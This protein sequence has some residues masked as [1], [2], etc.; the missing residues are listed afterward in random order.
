MFYHRTFGTGG[1]GACAVCAFMAN[2]PAML[3]AR[4]SPSNLIGGGYASRWV[5]GL[6][7]SVQAGE[8]RGAARSAAADQGRLVTVERIGTARRA[9]ASVAAR[10]QQNQAL[11][12]M[13]SGQVE[14]QASNG[15]QESTQ[16]QGV[17]ADR[18]L[19]AC[20]PTEQA[21]GVDARPA[22]RRSGADRGGAFP[23]SRHARAPYA[24]RVGATGDLANSAR[25]GTRS[26]AYRLGCICAAGS[27]TRNIEREQLGSG[28][29]G[30]RERETLVAARLDLNRRRVRDCV[31]HRA[32][33]GGK[34]ATL[35]EVG[36]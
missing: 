19:M 7:A 34:A 9:A 12:G 2:S 28:V 17:A 15:R 8:F 25:A 10:I 3:G 21:E 16:S 11:S 14:R 30:A 36:R 20:Y 23:L 33:D 13:A 6:R 24:R 22:G 29:R 5:F 1:G 35:G 32:C 31:S 27:G 4:S 18:R 26:P